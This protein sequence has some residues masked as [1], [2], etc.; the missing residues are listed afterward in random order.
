MNRSSKKII[1]FGKNID[2]GTGTFMLEMGNIRS[3]DRF[4]T[5]FLEKR[6]RTTEL[7]KNIEYYS[8]VPYYRNK[9]T[10]R[11][12]W[13]YE[14]IKQIM[15]F[16]KICKKYRPDMIISF[17][18]HC[19]LIVLITN[20]MFRLHFLT[21]ICW[22]NNVSAVLR[23]KVTKPL[24]PII[25][26]VGKYLFSHSSEIV[27]VT[28]GVANEVKKTFDIDRKITV[29]PYGII[30][31]TNLPEKSE[32][33]KEIVLI[34]VGRLE[35]QKDTRSLILAFKSL[36]EKYTF[37][38]LLILGDGSEREKLE[39]L[40]HNNG[41]EKSVK[42]LG[43]KRDIGQYLRK[44][45]I[46]VFSSFYEGFGLSIL[47]ALAYGLPIVATNSPYGPAEILENGKYGVL[48]PVGK[49]EK[50]RKGVES[51]I[52]NKERR[53]QLHKLGPQRAKIF[54]LNN[55]LNEYKQLIKKH[56]A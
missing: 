24:T 27:C 38:K 39:L 44:A 32:V 43:W 29:I 42:F 46:F 48:V 12:L 56:L 26:L 2:S 28:K 54:S 18:T 14:F 49:P 31:P 52:T 50:I 7:D 37:L 40:V 19:N 55:T 15:W 20:L 45:D 13:P 16:G 21:I 23:K 33:K 30:M 9:Y 17:N 5:L 6:Y 53:M 11:N 22:D 35:E 1:I 51:L 3:E 4:L 10:F 25:R 8:K 34:S 47:E 36:L 41:L